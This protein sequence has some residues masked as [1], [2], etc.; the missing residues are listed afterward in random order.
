MARCAEL[1]KNIRPSSDLHSGMLH[2]SRLQLGRIGLC[3]GLCPKYQQH[4]IHHVPYSRAVLHAPAVVETDRNQVLIS[5]QVLPVHQG[6]IFP[7]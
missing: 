7:S 6:F 3:L 5:L 1:K 2:G 4:A